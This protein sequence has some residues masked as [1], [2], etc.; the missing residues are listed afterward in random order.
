M[1]GLILA[2]GKG[3]RLRPLS[4]TRPK[5]LLPVANQPVILY[6]IKQLYE[7]GVREIG[8]VIQPGSEEIFEQM[9]LL[10]DMEDVQ[11]NYIY[12]R[13]QRG[14][15]HAVKQ[16][17]AF[18]GADP[19][20]LLLGDNLINES[21]EPLKEACKEKN[22]HGTVMVTKVERP[23][24]YGIAET[25][26]GRITNVEEKPLQPKSNLAII[27]VYLFQPTIFKAIHA[28]PPSA[29]GEYEITDAIQWLIDHKFQVN[30]VKAERPTFDVGTMERWLEANQWMLEQNPDLEN[31]DEVKNS[32]IIPP[33]KIGKQC[34]IKNS[35][36][37]PHVSIEPGT[38]IQ[39]C[40]IKNSII[41]RDSI[42]KNIPYKIVDSVFGEKTKFITEDV[43]D[44][45][46][47]GMFG[48]DSSF[49]FT[50]S[51]SKKKKDN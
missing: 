49:I 31:H 32:I 17:E 22:T 20:V 2:A 48:D 26:E 13:E 37:G 41:L 43:K 38:T 50:N 14:I 1:K 46:I 18:I 16:A 29:R 8:L 44:P 19:F 7:L 6:G 4:H 11:F 3:T 30:Y 24:D 51:S 42:F 9:L 45:S 10:E 34:T 15:A 5:P 40:R 28:I 23:E 27:G 39:N 21:L 35:V 25:M 12:Q 36:I 33:V 47:H